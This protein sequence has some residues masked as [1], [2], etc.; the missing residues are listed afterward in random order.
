MGDTVRINVAYVESLWLGCSVCI[1]ISLTPTIHTHLWKQLTKLGRYPRYL[2]R[3]TKTT[4][5]IT[6]QITVRIHVVL[7]SSAVGVYKYQER[8]MINEVKSVIRQTIAVIASEIA[9]RCM[10]HFLHR[11]QMKA[12]NGHCL[13][14]ILFKTHCK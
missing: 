1:H 11:Q 13:E 9:H 7:G 2:Q 10:R 8:L 6:T 12:K 3:L 4:N 14:N 5:L